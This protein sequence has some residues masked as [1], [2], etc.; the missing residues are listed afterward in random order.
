MRKC[1]CLLL[2]LVFVLTGCGTN[3][4]PEGEL[5]D[6]EFTVVPDAELPDNLK[7]IINERKQQPFQLSYATTDA[8]YIVEGFGTKD[9]GGFSVQVRSLCRDKDGI[10]FDTVLVGPSE[11]D[12]VSN[13]PSYPYIVVKTEF[14]DLPVKFP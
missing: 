7:T 10:Y 13:T 11:Q 8:L 4:A 12:R 3:S 9:T 6:L 2:I 1:I 14:L 5:V